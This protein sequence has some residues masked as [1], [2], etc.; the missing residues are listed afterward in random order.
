L[1]ASLRSDPIGKG[2]AQVLLAMPL[3]VAAALLRARA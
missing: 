2:M 1:L 3:K